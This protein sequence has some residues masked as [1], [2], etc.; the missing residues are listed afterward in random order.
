LLPGTFIDCDDFILEI[1][2]DPHL[3]IE[4][5]DSVLGVID[6]GL[7]ADLSGAQNTPHPALNS[8]VLAHLARLPSTAD[9][10]LPECETLLRDANP[11]AEDS[12]LFPG[13][14]AALDFAIKPLTNYHKKQNPNYNNE[15][16]KRT[17]PDP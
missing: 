13:G 17:M 3:G 9:C 7:S 10:S 5:E 6:R 15:N 16:G 11:R 12:E 8:I 14:I 2:S 1:L 4:D